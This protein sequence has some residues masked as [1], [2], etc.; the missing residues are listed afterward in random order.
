MYLWRSR[1]SYIL[2][3]NPTRES[4]WRPRRASSTSPY[5]AH[6]VLSNLP[7]S[8]SSVPVASASPVPS[9][10]PFSFSLSYQSHDQQAK[11]MIRRCIH[12]PPHP[13]QLGRDSL[14]EVHPTGWPSLQRWSSNIFNNSSNHNLSLQ[15]GETQIRF[16]FYRKYLPDVFNPPRGWANGLLSSSLY[17]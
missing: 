11:Y 6:L 10:Q 4:F 9:S 2:Q 16:L 7:H 13:Y 1:C 15:R 14:Q 12:T 5:I 8:I 17:Q 3:W